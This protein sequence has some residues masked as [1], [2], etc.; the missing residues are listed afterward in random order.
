MIGTVRPDI[1]HPNSVMRV[2]HGD[3]VAR[4]YFQ[5]LLQITTGMVEDGVQNQGRQCK[6]IH[7]VHPAGN[8]YLPEEMGMDFDQ[9]FH[10]QGCRLPGQVFDKIERFGDHETGA[11]G[12]FD[13]IPDCIQPHHANA[14]VVQSL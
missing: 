6:I 1:D 13:R 14:V 5:P 3:G 12:F 9:H 4:A 8:F 11:A 7:P 2:Q 10:I